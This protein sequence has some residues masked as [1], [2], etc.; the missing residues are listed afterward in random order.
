MAVMLW[1]CYHFDSPLFAEVEEQNIPSWH[2]HLFW[3]RTGR[4]PSSFGFLL[5]SYCLTV[6]VAQRDGHTDV[7]PGRLAS[8]RWHLP[9][10]HPACFLP[11]RASVSS[12]KWGNSRP[13]FTGF[14]WRCDEFIFIRYFSW[15]LAHSQRCVV[16]IQY[17]NICF[18]CLALWNYILK[19]HQPG[20]KNGSSYNHRS[21]LT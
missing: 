10:V 17:V 15:H 9:T 19:G 3:E 5:L 2:D 20:N 11:L 13:S 18:P 7:Q 1:L 21:C 16:V 8:Q 12:A 6:H 4:F 14:L